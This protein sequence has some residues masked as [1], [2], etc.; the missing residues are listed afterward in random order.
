M[1]PY[2]LEQLVVFAERGTLAAVSEKMNLSQPTITR[3]MKHLEDDFGVPLFIRKS[4]RIELTETGKVAVEQ[5]KNILS[6]I[7]TAKSTVKQHYRS[8]RTIK[9]ASCAPYP[10]WKLM[11]KLSAAHPDMTLSTVIQGNDYIENVMESDEYDVYI[12]TKSVESVDFF[13][14]PIMTEAL[15]VCVTPDHALA[16]HDAL[17]F[18]DINGHNFILRSEIGF[19]D[20]LCRQKMPASRFL[21]QTDPEAF[22]ELRFHSTL[23]YFATDLSLQDYGAP[24]DRKVIPLIDDDASVTY[25]LICQNSNRKIIGGIS[26]FGC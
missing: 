15:F 9:I 21:V 11:P 2:E 14:K 20:D 22:E 5:A 13:C 18:E 7:K 3:S 16:S 12:S 26:G 24:E 8:T 6:S 4:N 19:W 17:T 1:N 10:L 23:P 25:Y